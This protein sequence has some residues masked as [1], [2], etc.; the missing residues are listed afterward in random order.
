MGNNIVMEKGE[1]L[2][3]TNHQTQMVVL[4][5]G[6]KKNVFLHKIILNGCTL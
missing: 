6:S 4:W 1:K 2:S 3:Q 5:S